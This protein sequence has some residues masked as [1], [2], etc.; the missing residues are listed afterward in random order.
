MKSTY[1][2]HAQTKLNRN[3]KYKST[4]Y[5]SSNLIYIFIKLK[6]IQIEKEKTTTTT[7]NK[8]NQTNGGCYFQ[9][10]FLPHVCT[11]CTFSTP[12][13]CLQLSFFPRF[14]GLILKSK[15]IPMN[16][17]KRWQEEQKIGKSKKIFYSVVIWKIGTTFKRL[18]LPS[19]HFSLLNLY[20]CI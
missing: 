6:Q 12:Y 13:S 4:W 5:I 9:T 1:Q 11:A 10:S 8:T 14:S 17:T 16:G 2:K 3:H 15:G 7:N 20:Q 18:L 19:Q